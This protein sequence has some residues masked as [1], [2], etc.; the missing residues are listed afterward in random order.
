[1]E[2]KRYTISEA[3]EL[4]ELESHVLRYWEEEL[5]LNIPRN[6]MGH[7][8]YT[9]NEIDIFKKIKDFK[10]QGL[11]LKAIKSALDNLNKNNENYSLEI[12]NNSQ[13]N[14]A[15]PNDEKVKK[16]QI[17]I[18]NLFKEALIEYNRIFKEELKEELKHDLREEIS[19]QIKTIELNHEL[20]EKERYRKLDEAIREVQNMRK[21]SAVAVTAKKPWYKQVFGR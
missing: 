5:N 7:R 10:N 21:E 16:F 14:I 12:T 17:M 15:N 9:N 1:M 8:Y 6:E 4:L 13:V 19:S 18:R 20:K 2:E 11:Q 3:S